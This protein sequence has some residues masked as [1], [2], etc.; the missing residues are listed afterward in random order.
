MTNSQGRTTHHQS[1]FWLLD[2]FFS[3]N[4]VSAWKIPIS[5]EEKCLEKFGLY[6][7][8]LF[9]NHENWWGWSHDLHLCLHNTVAERTERKLSYYS[10]RAVL[11]V[12]ELTSQ[13]SNSTQCVCWRSGR[14]VLFCWF[15][16]LNIPASCLTWCKKVT[17]RV[18]VLPCLR[19]V[20]GC[21]DIGNN[22]PGPQSV[23]MQTHGLIVWTN[24]SWV[25]AKYS[26]YGMVR[27]FRLILA[28]FEQ[29]VPKTWGRSGSVKN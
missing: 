6:C 18:Q 27:G 22:S 17:L 19:V 20:L 11:M 15:F 1:E 10:S 7:S 23:S 25:A 13:K 2:S 4:H 29:K 24:R 16:G 5:N 21:Y 9:V 14:R 8:W 26:F 28:F 12:W 3:W